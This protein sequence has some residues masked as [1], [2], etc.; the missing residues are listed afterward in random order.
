MS[1]EHVVLQTSDDGLFDIVQINEKNLA[2]ILVFLSEHFFTSETMCKSV[3]A[4]EKPVF[5]M[6]FA[7]MLTMMVGEKMSVAVIEK[8]SN[9]YIA[10]ICF[11]LRPKHN[12]QTFFGE[13]AAKHCE[14]E[15]AKAILQFIDASG[16]QVNIYERFDVDYVIECCCLVTHEDFRRKDFGKKLVGFAIKSVLQKNRAVLPEDRQDVLDNVDRY[17]FR[18]VCSSQYSKLIANKWGCEDLCSSEFSEFKIKEYADKFPKN[19]KV[20][21]VGCK[22]PKLLS[23]YQ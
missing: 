4:L 11:T 16:T 10:A 19:Y 22:L 20:V 14:D 13:F 1:S 5:V 21:T 15:L 12:N 3:G 18:A 8:S 17:A 23:E 7:K 6:D 2:E 9:R